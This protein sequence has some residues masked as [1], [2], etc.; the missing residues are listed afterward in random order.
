MNDN[1]SY[2]AAHGPNSA[3][4]WIFAETVR[5]ARS[6]SSNRSPDSAEVRPLFKSASSRMIPGSAQELDCS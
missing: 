3:R 1:F 5:L 6:A 2:L 4:G